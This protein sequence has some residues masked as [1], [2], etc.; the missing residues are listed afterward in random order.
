MMSGSP[1][2]WKPRQQSNSTRTAEGIRTSINP[3]A[4][5]QLTEASQGSERPGEARDCTYRVTT[6]SYQHGRER[7]THIF[8]FSSKQKFQNSMMGVRTILPRVHTCLAQPTTGRTNHIEYKA[9]PQGHNIRLDTTTTE[10]E[11]ARRTGAAMLSSQRWYPV[12]RVESSRHS[13]PHV[14]LGRNEK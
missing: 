7:R 2:P 9:C 11:G 5:Q 6:E 1:K 12:S 14:S 8:V 13:L 3:R 10:R 4:I